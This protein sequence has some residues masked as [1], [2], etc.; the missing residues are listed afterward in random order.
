MGGWVVLWGMGLMCEWMSL[1]IDL[2]RF[3]EEF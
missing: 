2:D 1:E 3:I